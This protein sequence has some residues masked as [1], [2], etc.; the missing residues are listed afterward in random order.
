[1]FAIGA[2]TAEATKLK[3]GMELGIPREGFSECSGLP[4]FTPW[5]REAK[6]CLWRSMQPKPGIFEKTLLNKI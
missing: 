2:R 3:F 1:M 5:A 4:D 6:E